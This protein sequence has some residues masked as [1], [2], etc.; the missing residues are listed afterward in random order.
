MSSHARLSPSAAFRWTQCPG[1][2]REEANYPEERSGTAA[3]D[4]THSHT[5]LEESLKAGLDPS[6]WLG[7]TLKDDD[8]EFKVDRERADRVR[9]AYDYVKKTMDSLTNCQVLLEQ[10]VDAGKWFGRKDIKG[11][12]DVQIIGDDYLEVID[13]KDGMNEVKVEG[14]LQLIIYALGA[15][16]QGQEHPEKVR[17]TIIQPKMSFK[18]IS[19]I[20]SWEI[21]TDQLFE[22]AAKIKTAALATDDP[23][24][25]L[26]PGEHCKWCKHK[27]C[28]VR[29]SHSLQEAGIMFEDITKQA[30]D[31]QPTELSDE[32]IR[33]IMESA[34]L[35]R[36]ML[37]AVE[38]EAMRRMESGVKIDGLK[39]VHGRGS[40]AW[41]LPEE[42]MADRL[43]KM[44]IPKGAIYVTKLISPAQAPKVV[45]EKRDGS[46]KQLSERQVQT[47][48]NE[49]VSKK[50]GKLTVVT[51]SDHREA[52][53]FDVSD[54][55]EAVITEVTETTVTDPVDVLPDWLS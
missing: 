44:G 8:G 31:K 33:E 11:T 49:Y 39:V 48:E 54:Q 25:P 36:Q 41:A 18:G 2:P 38:E 40:R 10:K 5:L 7:E 46:K 45:W 3:I 22:Y 21:T 15:L 9:I 32:Q 52:V 6:N 47:L 24:A 30:A 43:R 16:E 1:A 35:I 4:G 26:V 12:A 50:Q 29:V 19:P 27:G 42:E 55:F 17:M 51:E 14:N 37:D 34:P 53:I 28:S 13:Y 20:N 23:N